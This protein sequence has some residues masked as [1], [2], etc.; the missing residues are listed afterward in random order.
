MK[1]VK[2]VEPSGYFPKEVLKNFEKEKTT[3]KQ[4][5]K[6]TKKTKKSK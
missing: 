2:Y 6:T 4:V 1:K 5:K 3:K